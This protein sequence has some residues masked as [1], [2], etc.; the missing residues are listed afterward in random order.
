MSCGM[1]HQGR[2]DSSTRVR[3]LSQLA[4]LGALTFERE[5]ANLTR[6]VDETLRDLQRGQVLAPGGRVEVRVE[7]HD[8]RA[9]VRVKDSCRGLSEAKV[10]RLF[11]PYY[12]G[13]S[14]QSASGL[15]IGLYLVKE[16]ATA[17][18]GEVLVT[19]IPGDGCEFALELP[20]SQ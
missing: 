8:G 1:L 6:V 16:I 2:S 5:P 3:Q 12:R 19:D 13:S 9:A 7:A 15:G 4:Q 17:L 10:S 18:G 14:Q 20:L 11:E